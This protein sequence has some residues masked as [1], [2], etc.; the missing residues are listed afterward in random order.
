M[1]D[2]TILIESVHGILFCQFFKQF[3][4]TCHFFK[5]NYNKVVRFKITTTGEAESSLTMPTRGY[6]NTLVLVSF[7]Y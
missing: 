3:C 4:S 1:A 2:S 5:P 7:L 6:T